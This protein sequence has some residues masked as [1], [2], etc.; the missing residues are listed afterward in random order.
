MMK[1]TEF[2]SSDAVRS[3]MASLGPA[4]NQVDE[5]GQPWTWLGALDASESF[6][7]LRRNV[8]YLNNPDH[9]HFIAAFRRRVRTA[10][11]GEYFLLLGIAAVCDFGHVAD[12][13]TKRQMWQGFY[14]R[15]DDEHARALAC[16]VYHAATA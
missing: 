8:V 7:D 2:R 14:A 6:R 3:L 13:T 16:C 15:L 10:S 5:E 11:T 12:Q 1:W 4:G 9:G